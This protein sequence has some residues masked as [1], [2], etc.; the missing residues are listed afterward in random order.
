M[1]SLGFALARKDFAM[2]L[3]ST[4][5]RF[6]L[7]IVYVAP[8]SF[9][10]AKVGM[11]N[12]QGGDQPCHPGFSTFNFIPFRLYKRPLNRCILKDLRFS[13]YGRSAVDPEVTE[14]EY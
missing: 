1:R 14:P 2:S 9:L 13:W 3:S 4:G 8:W 12:S 11:P 5:F 10:C 6:R 7:A